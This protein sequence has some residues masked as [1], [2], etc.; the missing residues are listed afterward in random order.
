ML[1]SRDCGGCPYKH[2]DDDNLKSALSSLKLSHDMIIKVKHHIDKRDYNAACNVTLKTHIPHSK[3][4]QYYSIACNN[5][6]INDW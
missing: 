1:G 6:F 5:K 3:P 2:Y 4:S